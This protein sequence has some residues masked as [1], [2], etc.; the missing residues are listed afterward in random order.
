MMGA[1][2]VASMFALEL[3]SRARSIVV[4][5][6]VQSIA[7]AVALAGVMGSRRG[8]EEIA[9]V[10]DAVL[11]SFLERRSA[12]GGSTIHVIVSVEGASSSAWASDAG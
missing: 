9:A 6:E 12:T 5:A 2:A 8:A 3:S 11:V 10:N 7:D 1:V 4:D